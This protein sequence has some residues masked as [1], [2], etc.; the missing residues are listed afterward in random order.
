[1]KFKGLSI[2][3]LFVTLA[4]CL[5]SC[6]PIVEDAQQPVTVYATLY[7]IFALTE[8]IATDVPDFELHCLVQ[9]QDGCLRSY[10]LSDW[11]L[12]MLAY[13]ANGVIAGGNGLESFSGTLETMAQEQLTLAEVLTGL[14]LHQSEGGTRDETS[15]YQGANPHLYMSVEGA[16]MIAENIAS[17]LSVL[18]ARYANLY[19]E[20]LTSAL[21]SLQ[22]LRDELLKQ[23]EVCNGVD[24][25]IM[26]E[27]LFY[28]AQDYG[29][30]VVA[31]IERESG[32][33]LYDSSLESCLETLRSS[34]AQVVL[35]EQQA[36]K[37]LVDAL[38]AEGFAVT[39]IDILSTREESD[40]A[41]G[42]FEAQ[43]ANAQA[44]AN[45]CRQSME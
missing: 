25:A 2:L 28:V 45:A 31:A 29:L 43:R 23:T 4:L 11:D 41:E 12:Y 7:P 26:N 35:I 14:D 18:D 1:M 6:S 44:L 30:N 22:L 8:M 5:S 33:G 32:E 24:A 3:A 16:M 36:P 17:A 9:P 10:E 13:S 21:A 34:S 19:E 20:N 40:G 27:A 42:Y 39:K 37:A 15:H 38:E